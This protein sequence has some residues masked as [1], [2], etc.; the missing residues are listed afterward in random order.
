[1]HR[2]Y[3]GDYRPAVRFALQDRRGY[4]RGIYWG[5]NLAITCTEDVPFVDVRAAALDN[6]RTLLGD[7]R[8]RQQAAACRGWPTYPLPADYHQPVP[9]RHAHPA[10]LR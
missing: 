2:A 3:E 4:Q 1:M 9:L 5:L 8:V 6:G 7:W 10:D